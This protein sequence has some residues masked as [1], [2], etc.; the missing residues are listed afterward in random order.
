M[1]HKTGGT[2]ET[3]GIADVAATPTKAAAD[4][5][6]PEGAVFMPVEVILGFR[7]P[8]IGATLIQKP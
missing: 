3:N 5:S 4:T 7:T 6:E 8:R 2:D 1:H